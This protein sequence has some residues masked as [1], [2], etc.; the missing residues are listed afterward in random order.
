MRPTF[1]AATPL[2]WQPNRDHNLIAL[3]FPRFSANF[4]VHAQI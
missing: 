4:R 1:D 3:N 2:R